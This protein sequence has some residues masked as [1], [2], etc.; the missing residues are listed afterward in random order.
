[1]RPAI[2]LV[3][4]AACS[5]ATHP[6]AQSAANDDPRAARRAELAAEEARMQADDTRDFGTCDDD[7]YDFR[8]PACRWVC[9]SYR[10]AGEPMCDSVCLRDAQRPDIRACQYVMPCPTPPDRRVAACLRRA[11]QLWP[12]CDRAHPVLA[13]PRCDGASPVP[14]TLSE[15]HVRAD[16]RYDLRI[17]PCANRG[18]AAGWRGHLV[19]TEHGTDVAGTDFAVIG[20]TDDQC[21]AITTGAID[22]ALIAHSTRVWMTPP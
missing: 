3:A 2:A 20:A 12:P 11:E 14:G 6:A 10:V 13:N 16:G 8:R 17:A 18:V 1:V 21:T 4:A 7:S 9:P 19:D 5:H 15:L 22:A